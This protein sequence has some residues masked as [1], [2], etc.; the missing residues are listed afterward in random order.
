M[1][2]LGVR[3]RRSLAMS[4]SAVAA[5][6]LACGGPA[7]H[8]HDA[9]AAEWPVLRKALD[10]ERGSL[11]HAPWSAQVRVAMR[12]AGRT[13]AGRGGIAASPG[14]ALRMILVGGPGATLL[15]V[16]VTRERWRM[17]VP[18]IG[19][20][21]RG[22]LDEPPDLPVGFLR[23]WFCTP[24]E[25]ELFAAA[26]NPEGATSWRLHEG[27]A[28]IELRDD[29]GAL[30]ASRRAHGRGQIVRQSRGPSLPAP[31]DTVHY[32]DEGGVTV[33]LVVESLGAAPPLDEAF[34]DPDTAP[35][36]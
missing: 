31:G 26:R 32:E 4:V 34:V 13:F 36:P 5:P 18:P 30:S 17:A 24:L 29:R 12:A 28:V 20:V 9:T 7:E 35:T 1:I 21:M 10:D 14:K 23:W 16:W 33:D 27:D 25:G 8:W 3:L 6:L 19:R 15:D 22:G 2:A 11:P